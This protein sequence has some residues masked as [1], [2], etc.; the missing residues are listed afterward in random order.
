[1]LGSA[2][3][4]WD[5]PLGAPGHEGTGGRASPRGE[6]PLPA[7]LLSRPGPICVSLSIGMA[8]AVARDAP[9]L[10]EPFASA[11]GGQQQAAGIGAV[12]PCSTASSSPDIAAV[13]C[14]S[15]R[16]RSTP[17]GQPAAPLLR[18]GTAPSA[19][20]LIAPARDFSAVAPW[21]GGASECR[22]LFPTEEAKVARKG[23][24]LP[25]AAALKTEAARSGTV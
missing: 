8:V 16:G 22:R 1:M 13:C 5:S 17:G 12:S 19:S 9:M 3:G 6:G 7:G 23:L 14:L 20:G 18:L 2:A 24:E 21:P 10:A 25:G 11:T 15:T 4:G